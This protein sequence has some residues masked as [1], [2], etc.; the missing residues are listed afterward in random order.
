MKASLLLTVGVCSLVALVP[1]A[2]AQTPDKAANQEIWGD[3][4]VGMTV[5][6]I[7]RSDRLPDDVPPQVNVPP[8]QGNDYATIVL[9][10]ASISDGYL[11]SALDCR[12]IDSEGNVYEE[13]LSK[14]AGGTL[15]DPTDVNSGLYFGEGASFT[16]FFEL[17]QRFG[18]AGLAVD[19]SYVTSED[20]ETAKKGHVDITIARE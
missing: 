15:R 11:N 8:Q 14:F 6:K 9:A 12:L 16:F 19:Y 17:P 4:I 18:P 1:P 3:E 7:E 2:A 5:A 10:I 13:T 20:D